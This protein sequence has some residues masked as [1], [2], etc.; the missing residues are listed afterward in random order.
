MDWGKRKGKTVWLD[1][2]FIFYSTSTFQSDSSSKDQNQL[3]VN[4]IS[5]L[6]SAWYA[7]DCMPRPPP[8]WPGRANGI[9]F[10][11]QSLTHA[12][13]LSP[14]AHAQHIRHKDKFFWNFGFWTGW[15]I[16]ISFS[17]PNAIDQIIGFCFQLHYSNSNSNI[18]LLFQSHC[19]LT[20]CKLEIVIEF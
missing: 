15:S 18:L 11:Y 12:V 3:A 5:L 6:T 16:L 4:H 10:H 1:S 14:P 13:L 8:A 9:Y 20:N 2:D 17:I 19:L 7:S